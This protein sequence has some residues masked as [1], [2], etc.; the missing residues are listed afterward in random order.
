[1]MESKAGE[2]IQSPFDNES[3]LTRHKY[4]IPAS[5]LTFFP[6][7]ALGARGKADEKT[8]PTR[9]KD[10]EFQYVDS[11]GNSIATSNCDIATRNGGAMRPRDNTGMRKFIEASRAAVGD[12]ISI[13]KIG[14]RH[15]KVELTKR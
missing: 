15:Y 1:M 6:R 7:D 11:N 10:V 2:T 3:W 5:A 8:F 12:S 14:A 9:G 4:E 13:T